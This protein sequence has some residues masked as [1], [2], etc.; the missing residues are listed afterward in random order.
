MLKWYEDATL[1]RQVATGPNFTTPSLSATTTY[2]VTET[3]N[4]GNIV[5]NPSMVT[6]TINALPAADFSAALACAGTETLFTN[7]S[8]GATSY[9]WDFGD[10]STSTDT[11]PIHRYTS[12]GSFTVKLT[13]Q[14]MAGCITTVSKQL[15]V[16]ANPTPLVTAAG[17]T[18]I[19]EGG[20]VTL[21]ASGSGDFQWF[22]DDVMIAGATTASFAA[23][24]AGKYRV[25]VRNPAGCL[26]S[27]AE[28][29][30]T[31]NPNPQPTITAAGPT[32]FCES[33]SV[34]LIASG[35]D[36][37]QWLKDDIEIAGAT[38]A[39]L[40]VTAAG[41]YKV[42][43]TN[44][45]GCAAT[46]A[47]TVVT[48]NSN[49]VPDFTATIECL[50]Q[51][52]KFTH[53]VTGANNYVWD[54]GDGSPV[55]TEPNPAHLY[56]NAGAFMVKLTALSA[57]GCPAAEI[58]RPVIVNPNPVADFATTTVCLGRPTEFTNKS[59]GAASYVW[60]FGD[61]TNSTAP[62]PTHTYATAGTFTVKLMAVSALVATGAGAAVAVLGAVGVWS[63]PSKR[64]IQPIP[65]PDPR[66]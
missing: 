62:N 39:M 50:G 34:T 61:G 9:V 22:Q 18:A 55:S 7:T 3:C 52:T 47:A 60:D 4:T 24:A 6:A 43:V 38:S 48:V 10:N 57:T 21:T 58:I 63:D 2:Y 40:T 46:S 14:S 19:C 33:G 51:P 42:L 64:P 44:A 41:S 65:P 16:N 56:A 30:V 23:S 15:V 29:T 53:T 31:V 5:S 13:A 54:F 8:T 59:I 17:P 36:R 32:T 12:A 35:G 1:T 37:F 45:A 25:M 66:P 27:S 28:T 11:D 26:S 20:S 49:P